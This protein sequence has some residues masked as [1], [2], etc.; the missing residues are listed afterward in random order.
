MT[1]VYRGDNIL[2]GFDDDVRE[3]LR[4]EMEKRG[5]TSS[6]AAP[7]TAVEKAGDALL[8]AAVRRQSRSP[9]TR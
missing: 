4:G 9:P 6:P 3:H 8:G 7:S 5:I 1:L 2:R